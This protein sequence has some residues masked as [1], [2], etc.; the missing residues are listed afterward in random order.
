MRFNAVG[1][2]AF[3]SLES[4]LPWKREGKTKNGD[5]Y[6]SVNIAIA[7]TKANRMM[8]ECFGCQQDEIKTMDTDNNKISISWNDRNDPDVISK[9]AS[10]R[11]HVV[12]L[13]DNRK[14]FISDYDFVKYIEENV[15]EL[16]DGKYMITGNSNINEYNGKISQ[17]F[18]IQ[19]IYRVEDETKNQLKITFDYYWM[20]DGVDFNDWKDEKK[21]RI[22]GYTTAYIPTEKKNMYVAQDVVFDAS[23]IDFDNEKHVKLLAYKLKQ[24]GIGLEDGKPVNKL[25][26]NKVY[27]LQIICSYFNG[28]QEVEIDESMLN[29]NQRMAIELGLKTIKDFAEGSVYGDRIIEYKVVDF[30]LKGDYE[31]GCIT[32]DE[33]PSEFEENIYTP[34][35]PE[36]EEEILDKAIEKKNKKKKDSDDD[37]EDWMN[38]PEEDDEDDDLSDLFD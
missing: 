36:T 22:S 15:D 33:K 17:R 1:S 11:K 24:M 25:K 4:K 6:M 23:K 32:L 20:S 37:D 21:I 26:K 30:N 29:E 5:K 14:E 18:Q 27:K 9:V 7:S 12:D 28:A 35:T 3:N 38:K 31:D 19:N 2:L 10:Y 16:K 34:V 13:G 8:S